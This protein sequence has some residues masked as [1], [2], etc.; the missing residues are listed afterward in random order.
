MINESFDDKSDAIINPIKQKVLVKC[1]ICI[2]TFSDKI[3]RFVIEQFKPKQVG[4]FKCVNGESPIYTFKYKN[5][6][7]GFYKTLLGAPASV[8]MLEKVLT[9]LGSTKFLVFGSAGSL[10]KNIC[11]NKVVVPTYAYRD[12][13]TSYHYAPAK[14]YIKIK[15]STAVADFMKNNKIPYVE[16]RVWTTD[17]FYRETKNNFNKRKSEG[18][19][20]VDMECSAMQAVCDLRNLELYYFFVSGDLLDS[21]EWTDS[22]LHS[23]N[24]NFENFNI[25]LHLANEL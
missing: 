3:E 6:N 15:N 25:A 19:I 10:D 20:A 4:I 12:E 11:N 14:D 1:D 7:I 2:A 22:N 8:G 16:G 23:A 13:G 17:A 21:P 18:C 9:I 5:K 24:H